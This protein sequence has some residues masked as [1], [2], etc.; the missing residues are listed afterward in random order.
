M[1]TFL[2][3][4]KAIFRIQTWSIFLLMF[5]VSS[6]LPAG[7]KVG[8]TSFQFLKLAPDARSAGMGNAFTSVA[9]SANAGFWN[10]AR[11]YQVKSLNFS[12]SYIDYFV[13]VGISSFAL[14]L[15]IFHATTIGFQAMVV[16]YGEIEVTE[17]GSQSWNADYTHFN[18]GLTGETIYPGAKMFGASFARSVTDKFVYGLTAK[19]IIEDLVREKASVLAFDGGLSYS[20]RWNSITIAASVRNFGPEVKFVNESYPIPETFTFGISGLLLGNENAVLTTGGPARLLV[21]YDLTHPRDYDQQ[22]NIGA[23]LTLLGSVSVRMGYKFNYDEE[24]ITF[25]AGLELKKLRVDYAFDPFGNI[26]QSIHRFSIGYG[27]K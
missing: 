19:Y 27:L 26:L 5:I 20:T 11:I 22:H 15:P 9:N 18:P 8:T 23:E 14:A 2:S 3:P 10:P 25:G 6:P 7:E 12:A 21:A 17:V 1:M 4:S 16:D 24:N 13:D